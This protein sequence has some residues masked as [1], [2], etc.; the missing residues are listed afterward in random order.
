MADLRYEVSFKGVASPTLRAA[1]I[2]CEL[3]TGVGT[4]WVR[5]THDALRE[6][7]ARIEELGLELL[8]VR[9]IAAH[10]P[11]EDPSSGR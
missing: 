8:D 10:S 4:T 6:I 2:G 1:F 3:G 9:L 7:I 11:A 5:C